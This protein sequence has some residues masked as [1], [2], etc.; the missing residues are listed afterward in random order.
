MRL[1]YRTS[2]VMATKMEQ[3]F[4]LT[5]SDAER[6]LDAAARLCRMLWQHG[7]HIL[8]EEKDRPWLEMVESGRGASAVP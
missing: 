7:I 5:G 4:L 2:D 3:I 6:T 8:A 1:S